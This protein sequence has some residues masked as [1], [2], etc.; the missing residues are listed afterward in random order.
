MGC[1]VDDFFKDIE[2]TSSEGK[3]LPAWHG[4]LYLEFHRGTYTSH[5]SIKK[6]NRKSEILLRD[7]E[8][9][10]TLASV[11]QL[12]KYTYPKQKIDDNWER[13][14]L[15]QFHDVLPGSSIGMVYDDAEKI[16]AQIKE[17][18]K[19]LLDDALGTLLQSSIGLSPDEPLPVSS[20]GSVVAFNS[21]MFPRLDVVK[22][23]LSG[24][25]GAKLRSKIVQ[26]SEDGKYGYALMQS[27]AGLGL[28]Q[29][30]GLFADCHAASVQKT[31]NGDFVLRNSAVQ[32]TISGG[33]ITSLVDSQLG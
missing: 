19:E 20:S 1:S 33:R 22:V 30:R 31:Q 29:M 18:G 4:E 14:L 5:G 26:A 17:E 9:V 28:A 2:K 6:G 12:K 10:A 11:L 8:L 15:C 32:M 7:V 21:T 23:P 3:A 25:G 13:L 24:S 16:Y 27:D